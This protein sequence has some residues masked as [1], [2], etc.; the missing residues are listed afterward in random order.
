MGEGETT[1]LPPNP[2]II[3][4]GGGTE[5]EGALADGLKGGGGGGGGG[6]EEETLDLDAKEITSPMT[7]GGRD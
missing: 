4:G 7:K 5:N 6:G 1:V 2:G 3:G